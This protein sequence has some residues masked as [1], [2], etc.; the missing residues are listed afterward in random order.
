[1][2]DGH[3]QLRTPRPQPLYDFGRTAY[4]EEHVVITGLDDV[5]KEAGL[6]VGDV[7][8]ALNEQ[9][10]DEY[11][12][13]MDPRLRLGST[14]RNQR[15]SAL[16]HLLT[17]Y[18]PA[19]ELTVTV[20]TA[21]GEIESVRLPLP[22]APPDF[23]P[24]A[25]LITGERL[26]S[27]VGLIEMGPF[28]SNV[29]GHDMVAE[30][31]AALNELADAPGLI[32]DL[33]RNGGGNSALAAEMAGRLL[34]EPFTYGREFYRQRLPTR[35]WWLWSERMVTP[36]PPIYTGPVVVLIDTYNVSTA[37][38]FIVALVDSG[39]AQTVGRRTGGSTGNPLVFQ[40]PGDATAQFSTGD[41]RRQNGMRIEGVGIEPDLPVAWTLEDVRR[42]RDPDVTAA[43]ELLLP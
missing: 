3:T 15:S 13:A 39:R 30:F 28:F 26:P 21:A 36:R 9:P 24:S 20:E 42:G 19:T 22:E 23:D 16:S 43:V 4:I 5:A 41:L 11:I 6:T 38:E 2:N 27:G 25:P 12:A 35:A 10:V 40:L 7:V 37:E 34:D 18:A 14:A 33:R 17:L 1:L 32:L 31:D 29:P 8:T